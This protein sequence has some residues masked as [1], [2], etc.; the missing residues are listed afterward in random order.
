MIPTRWALVC[1][2]LAASVCV[3][4]ALVSCGANE[5]GSSGLDGGAADGTSGALDATRR[6]GGG[7]HEAGSHD[8]SRSDVSN[9]DDRGDDALDDAEDATGDTGDGFGGVPDA[10]ECV[11]GCPAGVTCGV[12]TDCTGATLLCGKV[13][14][15][16]T[17]CLLTAFNPPTQACQPT[18]SCTGKCGIVGADVCGT[19]ISCGGCDGGESC[20]NHACVPPVGSDAGCEAPLCAPAGSAKLCG[21]VGNSCGMTIACTCPAGQECTNGVCGTPPPE[22]NL[23]DGGV[24]G[25]LKC[26]TVE[27]A[28]GSGTI[29]C[30]GTCTGDTKCVGNVCTSCTPPACGTAT[31]GTVNNGCGPSVSCGPSC[32]ANVCYEGACCTPSTCTGVVGCAPVKLGCG[33]TKSCNPC[34]SGDVC[35]VDS[36]TCSK[37]SPKTCADFGDAGCSHADS[38]GNTLNCCQESTSCVSGICCPSGQVNY[39]GTCCQPSCAE[40]AQSGPQVSCGVTLFCGS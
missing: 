27:N 1:V 8:S 32:G 31:C 35:D 24:E 12:W 37:C 38:C 19:G 5:E 18:P 23:G 10:P 11:P 17:V 9:G 6:D 16:G 30:G 22:C 39:K 4:L 3:P 15:A 40:E 21:T 25:G 28:C 7:A 33:V 36:G 14:A 2:A 34:P 20:V 29:T 13:C 26:G